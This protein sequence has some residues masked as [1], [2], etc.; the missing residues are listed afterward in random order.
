M[1]AQPDTATMLQKE[2][3]A[4]LRRQHGHFIDGQPVTSVHVLP[5]F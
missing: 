2:V 4:F 3:A 5:G 1:T